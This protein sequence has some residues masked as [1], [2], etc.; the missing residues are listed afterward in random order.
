M[1]VIPPLTDEQRENL[2]DFPCDFEIKAMGKTQDD[3][4]AI[5]VSIISPHC[6]DLAENA[7][8]QRSSKGGKYLSVS[9]KIQAK[10][11]NHIDTI[12]RAL[13]AH[14]AIVMVL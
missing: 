6:V 10:S 7:V 4:D 9:V 1:Q 14:P 5:V 3:F 8:R 2:L 12:Y 13:N 11:Q